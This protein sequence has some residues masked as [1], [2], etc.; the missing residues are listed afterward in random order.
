MTRSE[1]VAKVC[2][3]ILPCMVSSA[4]IYA[5]VATALPALMH[6]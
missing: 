5:S 6:R 2:I 4:V 3:D 1:V